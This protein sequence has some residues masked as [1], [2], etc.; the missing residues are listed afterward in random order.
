VGRDGESSLLGR[1]A[2]LVRAGALMVRHLG[3]SERYRYQGN[4][5]NVRPYKA[6]PL[7]RLSP[8]SLP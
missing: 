7:C 8:S 2:Y 1:R 6:H 5:W 4:A 3:T